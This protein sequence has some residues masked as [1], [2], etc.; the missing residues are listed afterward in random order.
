MASELSTPIGDATPAYPECVEHGVWTPI[1]VVPPSG[2]HR[3][4]LKDIDPDESHAVKQRGVLSFHAVGC[5]GDFKDHLAGLHVAK[6]MA[7]QISNP[8]VSAGSSMAVGTSFLFHLGDVV[9]KDEDPADPLGKDQAAMYNSQFYAQFAGY[10]RNIFAI[11]GNHDGKSSD[12]SKKSAILHFLQNFCSS[13]RVA[14]PDNQTDQRLTMTQAY[15]YWLFETA[16]AYIVGLYTND[17]NGGQLDDPMT[18]DNP[19]Y[20]WLVRSLKG[21]KDAADGKVVFLALHYPPYSGAANFAE[22]GDPNLGPTPRRPPP[23]G[24]LQPLSNILQQ[25]FHESAQYP[26]VVISAHAHLYQRITYSYANGWQIPYLIAGSG[27]HAPVEKLSKTCSGDTVTLPSLP[28]DVVLPSGS[29]LP[30]GDSAKVVAYND[31]EF[32]FLRF[33]V[34]INK[35]TV[36]G[37]FFAAYDQSNPGAALPALRDSFTLHLEKHTVE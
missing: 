15:P 33:T 14:S 24:V 7:A 16:V 31:Q 4:T 10:D 2:P 32:G 13:K 37:E 17:I 5:S 35:K 18:T 22:R 23:A 21:I 34:D 26:D 30:K 25:A 27:G 29:A 3:L 1:P 28:F 19:Q 36:L 12:H 8:R 6:A 9:Y 11:P 20:Q